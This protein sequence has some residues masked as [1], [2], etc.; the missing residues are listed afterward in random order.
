MLNHGLINYNPKFF[1][2]LCRSNAYRIAYF[3]FLSEPQSCP[4]PTTS[5][6]K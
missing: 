3:N 1:W 4:L 6:K 2:M 5:S